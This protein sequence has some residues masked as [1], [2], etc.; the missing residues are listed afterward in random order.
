MPPAGF[1][2]ATPAIVRLQTYASDGTV[3]GTGRWYTVPYLEMFHNKFAVLVLV[4]SSFTERSNGIKLQVLVPGDWYQ[5]LWFLYFTAVKLVYLE[6]GKW[7]RVFVQTWLWVW[8]SDGDSQGKVN[9]GWSI[10][11]RMRGEGLRIPA[12]VLRALSLKSCLPL[13]TSAVGVFRTTKT[14]QCCLLK[15]KPCKKVKWSRYRPG[16]AQ[17][18]GRGIAL[19]FHDRGTR[20][21]W[22]VSSTPRPNFTPGKDPVPILQEA[23]W[24]PGLVWTAG[25]SRPHR[26]SIPERPALSQSLYR[27]SYPAHT[28]PCIV[29]YIVQFAP[30]CRDKPYIYFGEYRYSSRHY[31][32]QHPIEVNGH[33]HAPASLTPQE[34]LHRPNPLYRTLCEFQG[35]WRCRKFQRRYSVRQ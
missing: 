17:R 27:L 9:E 11:A 30:L 1:D 23:G 7:R 32:P 25:K 35:W 20:K 14:S 31:L 34:K 5:Q 4:L 26:D 12:E 28:K 21:E 15:P 2:P 29:E 24:A 18:V 8:R 6:C 22:V 10:N 19:L 33:F 3:A 13:P 16:V